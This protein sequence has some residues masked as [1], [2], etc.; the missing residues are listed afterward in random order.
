MKCNNT[1]LGDL[2]VYCKNTVTKKTRD[3]WESIFRNTPNLNNI[4]SAAASNTNIE[5]KVT[6]I[7]EQ[8]RQKSEHFIIERNQYW[9]VQTSLNIYEEWIDPEE[10]EK[11]LSTFAT[12]LGRKYTVST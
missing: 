6:P 1:D 2:M 10:F 3:T 12:R 11:R 9:D 4:V 5:T 7:W 8:I